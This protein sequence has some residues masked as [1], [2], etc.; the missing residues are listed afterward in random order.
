MEEGG[1]EERSLPHLSPSPPKG[2]GRI[3]K[4]LF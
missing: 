1:F 2:R 4:E 3:K